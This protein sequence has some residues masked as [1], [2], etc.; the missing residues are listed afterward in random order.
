VLPPAR[1]Y[2]DRSREDE[3]LIAFVQPAS[4]AWLMPTVI[5]AI[6]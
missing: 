4:V 3:R 2:V 1:L 5:V 6:R